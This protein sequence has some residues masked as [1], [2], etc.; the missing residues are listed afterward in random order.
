MCFVVGVV[1][2]A[3]SVRGDCSATVEEE[4]FGFKR[5]K[6]TNAQGYHGNVGRKQSLNLRRCLAAVGTGVVRWWWCCRLSSS[7]A[8][9]AGVLTRDGGSEST[10]SGLGGAGS[11][12]LSNGW[13][14]WWR[15]SSPLTAP[16]GQVK[17]ARRAGGVR[18]QSLSLRA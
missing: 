4:E 16:A 2:V 9:L 7:G 10:S 5:F 6:E 13:S 17:G 11:V 1:V 8:A 14:L 12:V 15:L 18:L 3:V